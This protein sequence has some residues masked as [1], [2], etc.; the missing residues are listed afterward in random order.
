MAGS[1]ISHIEYVGARCIIINL[2]PS[3]RP[4]YLP[5]IA[6]LRKYSRYVQ[7]SIIYRLARLLAIL[8]C[9]HPRAIDTPHHYHIADLLPWDLGLGHHNYLTKTLVSC[10]MPCKRTGKSVCRLKKPT[11]NRPLAL[12]SK[13]STMGSFLR[14]NRLSF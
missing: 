8:Q 4:P 9:E 7:R 14:L 1:Y 12:S 5:L 13:V 2:K 11:R 6:L 10:T 3:R